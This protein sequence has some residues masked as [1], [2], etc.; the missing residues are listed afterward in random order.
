[1][2]VNKLKAIIKK[3]LR[4]RYY[5]TGLNSLIAYPNKIM[6]P[7]K[8]KSKITIGENCILR[9][10]IQILGHGGQVNVG[11]Y[12]FIGENTYIW[13][14]KRIE[15]GHRVLI[16]HNCNIFDNDIHPFDKDERHEQ[17]KDIL[18][19]GHPKNIK[20]NDA[21]VIIEDDVWIGANVT[22][23]KGVRVGAGAI[24]GA[25][26]VVTKDIEPFTVNVG[27]PSKII[28]RINEK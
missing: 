27:N 25:G 5:M 7:S 16:G 1:M 3:I 12:C 11:D 22:I 21:E 6:N 28:R 20:L 18:L 10:E 4:I 14:G 2:L 19:D 26:S 17:F 24:I 9:C 13:S 8:N 15:I 23:M